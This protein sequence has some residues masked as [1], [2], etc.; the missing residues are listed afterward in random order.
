MRSFVPRHAAFARRSVRLSIF[1]AAGI[2]IK[3]RVFVIVNDVNVNRQDFLLQKLTDVYNDAV[4]V[5]TK[6]IGVRVDES[7][8]RRLERF[9]EKTKIEAVTLTRASLEASLDFY[10]A[11]G[12]IRFPLVIQPADT[13]TQSPSKARRPKGNEK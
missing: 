4:S 9:E 10:E 8:E 2:F 13:V 11:N 7:T 6:I 3:C 1:V 12:Y 5:K